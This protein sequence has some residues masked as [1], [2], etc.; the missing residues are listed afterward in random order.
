MKTARP[1][2]LSF[3]VCVFLMV[4]CRSPSSGY[5]SPA[6]V[7]PILG[8]GAGWLGISGEEVRGTNYGISLPVRRLAATPSWTMEGG[9]NPPVLP[10]KAVSL[11]RRAFAGEFPDSKAWKVDSLS[12]EAYDETVQ[13][14][15][16]PLHDKRYYVVGFAPP[17]YKPADDHYPVWVLMDGTVVLPRA[18]GAADVKAGASLRFTRVRSIS[19]RILPLAPSRAPRAASRLACPASLAGQGFFGTEGRG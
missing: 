1:A 4:G 13:D 16:N 2:F 3:L 8:G 14:P 5:R 12:I 18:D 19:E 9:K 6:D 15:A 11:A 17:E 10:G 7:D